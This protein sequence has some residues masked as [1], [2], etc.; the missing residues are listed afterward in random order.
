MGTF[1]I[2]VTLLNPTDATRQLSVDCTVDSG[3][4]YSQLPAG[5]LRSIGLTPQEECPARLADGRE[6]TYQVGEVVFLVNGRRTTAKVIFAEPD[7]PALVGAMTL[8]GLLLGVDPVS[9]RLIPVPL[10]R[11]LLRLIAE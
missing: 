9:R 11:F 8:E 3:A 10:Q 7:A 4:T 2:P 6:E 1:T 5:L